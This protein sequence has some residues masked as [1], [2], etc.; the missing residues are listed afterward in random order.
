MEVT[1][2]VEEGYQAVVLFVLAKLALL[3]DA[4]LSRSLK[5]RWMIVAKL[6]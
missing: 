2:K 3:P 4:I 1:T 6:I 5:F